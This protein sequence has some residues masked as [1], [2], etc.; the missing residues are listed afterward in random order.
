MS[1]E[2]TSHLATIPQNVFRPQSLENRRKF[3]PPQPTDPFKQILHLLRLDQSLSLNLDVLIL[4]SP[5][6]IRQSAY[7]FYPIFAGCENLYQIGIGVG[8][9]IAID[10]DTAC[11][12]RDDVGNEYDPFLLF[13]G[14]YV[15]CFCCCCF[16]IGNCI[17]VFMYRDPCYSEPEVC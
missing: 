11:F 1:N 13:C 5:A 17:V 8:G 7:G 10:S 3:V 15:C 4:T 16:G 9:M 12:A 6:H 2:L 14:V